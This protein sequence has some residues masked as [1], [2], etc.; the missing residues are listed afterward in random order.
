MA[1]IAVDAMG[2]DHAPGVV[3]EGAVQACR[4][5]GADVTLV[6]DETR[7]RGE[8]VRLGAAD[9]KG[10]SVRHASQVV[11]MHEHPGQAIRKKRDASIRV[12]FDLV[13][14]GEA[15]AAMSAGNSGAMLAAALFVLGRLPGV[16]RPAIVAFLPT[17]EG[18]VALLDAG[19]NVDV[20]PLHLVQFALLGDVYTR[21]VSGV[22][23]PRIGVLSNGEELSKGTALT[24]S[25]VEALAKHPSIDFRGYAE[26][27]DLFSG[28]FDVVVTD[29]F[30][31][32]V[33]LKTAE[34]TAWAFRQFL[35]RN[36][37]QSALA[38]VGAL[39]MKPVFD[40]VR[41]KLD[42]AEIGGAPLIGCDGTVIL[43][44]GR[45]GARAI[46]N[47]IRTANEAAGALGDARE[48]ITAACT[49]AEGLLPAVAP[50][51]P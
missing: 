43:A 34:G 47:A 32:N 30:T 21:R 39:F 37:E 46:R 28:E 48:E 15:D 45:S 41:K 9:Q 2:G 17:L 18:R 7:I 49:A 44:H 23:R 33:V 40:G 10:I 6:G 14:S 11:E 36:I 27:K 24:R 29:G 16:E 31:G 1:R 4:E 3:V 51:T 5:L 12:V 8:L 26:G 20:K 50:E 38:K 22:P 19:A 25:V 35:K 42:Y 13:K